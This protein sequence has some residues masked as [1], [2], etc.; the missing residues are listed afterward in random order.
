MPPIDALDNRWY[1][2][3]TKGR[4]ANIGTKKALIPKD[5]RG[6]FRSRDVG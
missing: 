5:E 2:K 3:T 6:F 4:T 1:A